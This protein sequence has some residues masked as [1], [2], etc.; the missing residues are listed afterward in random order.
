MKTHMVAA[1]AIAAMTALPA[2]ATGSPAVGNP[3]TAPASVVVP[4]APADPY[5][6]AAW[7]ALMDEEGEYA[8]IAAYTAV[9]EKYGDTVEPYASIV[10]SEYR[11][12]DAL[13]RQLQRLGV[14]VPDNP[15][16]GEIPAPENLEDAALAWAE[17]EVANV[18]LYDNLLE[19]VQGD[20]K[21]ARVFTNLRRA[22][23]D[24]HLPLF[25]MAAEHGGQLTYAQM[26][27]FRQENG[28]GRGKGQRRGRSG[29]HDGGGSQDH[30]RGNRHGRGHGQSRGWR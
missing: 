6:A 9:L 27:A 19:Q 16:L 7:V 18:E 15:W 14:H 3:P 23:Q 11:H 13:I 4:E 30:G 22:S 26:D 5:A 24:H 10:Q 21:L 20:A 8:A 17:G 1:L 28:H 12:A 25:G 29:R 2:T